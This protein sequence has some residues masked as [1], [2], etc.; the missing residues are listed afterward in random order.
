MK[1]PIIHILSLMLFLSTM[2]TAQKY[3]VIGIVLDSDTNEPVEFASIMLSESG[4]W[5]ITNSEGQFTL[6]NVPK[7]KNSLFCPVFRL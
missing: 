5:A 1:S 3:S 7:G 6:K 4:L 2:V